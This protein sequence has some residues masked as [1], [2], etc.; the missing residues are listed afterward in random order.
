MPFDAMMVSMAVVTVFVSF[1]AVLMWA[2]SQTRSPE[3][4]SGGGQRGS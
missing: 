2:D 3:T 1:A 4:R